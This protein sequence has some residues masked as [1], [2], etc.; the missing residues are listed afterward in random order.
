M[1]YLLFFED[2]NDILQ[3]EQFN[4]RMTPQNGPENEA[5]KNKFPGGRSSLLQ[6][7]I[8]DVGD[9]FSSIQGAPVSRLS[10]KMRMNEFEGRKKLQY[11]GF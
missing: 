8:G 7:L 5:M 9:D 6:H 2:N 11:E 4:K 3:K 1:L 10:S